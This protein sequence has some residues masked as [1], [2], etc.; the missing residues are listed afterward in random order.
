MRQFCIGLVV[1]LIC[2]A[3]GYSSFHT[4][5]ECELPHVPEDTA[6]VLEQP[7]FFLSDTI[8]IEGLYKACDYYEIQQPDIVVAQAILETGLFKSDLCIEH[9]NLFGLYNSRIK[10]YYHFNHWTESVKAYR[11]KV[12]YRYQD[13][14]YYDWL[15]RIGYAEDSLYVSKLKNVKINYNLGVE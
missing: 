15:E 9:H 7:E 11:N 10:E 12:Q 6:I 14:D 1:G 8:T 3:L 5:V 2:G 4:C 13:G